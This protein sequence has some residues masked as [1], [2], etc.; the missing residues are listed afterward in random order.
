MALRQLPADPLIVSLAGTLHALRR[1][2]EAALDCVRA[3]LDSPRS[4]GHT[5]HTYYQIA[6]VH[7]LHGDTHS[8][9]G[10]LER[11]VDSGFA[12][13]PYFKADPHLARLR[14]NS[15]FEQLVA[16]LERTY[17]IFEITQL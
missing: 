10:W 4:F 7:A 16:D 12:C 6:S 9:M 2:P 3:A 15:A 8:A 11:S 13:W 17:G 14:G 5:H 1:E